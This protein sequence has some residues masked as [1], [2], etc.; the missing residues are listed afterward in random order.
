ME[1]DVSRHVHVRLAGKPVGRR[2]VALE[3]AIHAPRN[4]DGA[5]TSWHGSARVPCPS[6]ALEGRRQTRHGAAC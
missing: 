1:G 3:V 6:R 4:G 2:P 5:T